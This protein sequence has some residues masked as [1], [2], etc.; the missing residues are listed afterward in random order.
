[1]GHDA[2]H[3]FRT[4]YD[5]ALQKKRLAVYMITGPSAG[6]GADGGAVLLQ[7]AEKPPGGAGHVPEFPHGGLRLGHGIPVAERGRDGHP[8]LR[9]HDR[10]RGGTDA[11]TLRPGRGRRRCGALEEA[12]L[13]PLCQYVPPGGLLRRVRGAEHLPQRGCVPGRPIRPAQQLR[14]HGQRPA[15]LSGHGRRR[16]AGTM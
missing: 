15:A 14:P 3:A 6:R 1:M 10:H 2:A 7:P 12:M 5:P 9:G 13:E 4:S 16:P 11:P 8:P